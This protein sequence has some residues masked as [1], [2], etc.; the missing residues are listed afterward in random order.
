MKPY[1]KPV[2]KEKPKAK[3][4]K[5]RSDKRAKQE[6]LYSKQRKEY[7]E[8]NPICR[9]EGCNLE[10]TSTHHPEG[11]IGHRLNDKDKFIGLCMEHHEYIERNPNFAKANGYSLSRLQPLNK[12]E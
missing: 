9:F 7:L 6:R 1:P 8:E 12:T 5:P 11:R 4:I 3:P 2:K 10:A